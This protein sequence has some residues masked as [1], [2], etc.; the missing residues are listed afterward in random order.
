[1]RDQLAIILSLWGLAGCAPSTDDPEGERY[2]PML[3]VADVTAGQVVEVQPFSGGRRVLIDAVDVPQALAPDGLQPAG[4]AWQSDALLLTDMA[5][6]RVLAFDPDDGLPHGLVFD[7]GPDA[8]LE[9]PCALARVDGALAVLGNDTRNVLLLHDDGWVDELGGS[10]P[11]EIRDGHALLA[12]P[13][14]RLLVAT[15]PGTADVGLLQLWSL[16]D[17]RRLQTW[18]L[19]GDALSD[20]TGLAL[21]PDGL[22]YVVDW[23]GAQLLRVDPSD[24]A[25]V[26]QVLGPQDL[27]DPVALAFDPSGRLWIL[28]RRG[29]VTWSP[30]TGAERVL[31]DAFDF[32]RGLLVVP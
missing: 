1:M 13:E 23:S 32:G 19:P 12:L 18:L 22:V 9:E 2:D 17:G 30:S 10:S 20:A 15:S 7:P 24:G 25:V 29:L 21:G 31:D 11:P 5:S 27:T 26:D 14:D 4:M 8:S 6:G 16:Q 3:L 28:E